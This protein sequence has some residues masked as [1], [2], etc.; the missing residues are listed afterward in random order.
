MIIS[1]SITLGKGFARLRRTKNLLYLDFKTSTVQKSHLKSTLLFHRNAFKNS[2]NQFRNDPLPEHLRSLRVADMDMS[3]RVANS[4]NRYGLDT[5]GQ[6]YDMLLLR[7]EE[8]MKFRN[9]GAGSMLELLNEMKE[10][11]IDIEFVSVSDPHGEQLMA[12]K[13]KRGHDD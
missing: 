6:V 2:L 12:A 9:F 7:T 11:G 5:F 10:Y 1:H 4:L 3:A 8:L 13:V